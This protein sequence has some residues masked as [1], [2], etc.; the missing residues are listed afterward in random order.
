MTTPKRPYY[1]PKDPSRNYPYYEDDPYSR[2][3]PPTPHAPRPNPAGNDWSQGYDWENESAPPTPAPAPRW[4]NRDYD[5]DSAPP[6]PQS[7]ASSSHEWPEFA[8][9]SSHAGPLRTSTTQAGRFD[10]YRHAGESRTSRHDGGDTSGHGVASSHSNTVGDGPRPGASTPDMSDTSTSGMSS[11]SSGS[12]SSR[13]AGLGGLGQEPIDSA[14]AG[15][16][17]SSGGTAYF[18]GLGDKHVPTSPSHSRLAAL[19]SGSPPG[20]ST[21]SA[22][23]VGSGSQPPQ[24]PASPTA[25]PVSGATHRDP[26]GFA[27][28]GKPLSRGQQITPEIGQE[29]LELNR[30]GLSDPKIAEILKQKGLK[31][32]GKA[33][34]NY[35]RNVLKVGSAVAPKITPKVSKFIADNANK[36]VP[37]TEISTKLRGQ[38]VEITPTHISRYI[39]EKLNINVK[40]PVVESP[41]S[42][43]VGKRIAELYNRDY[44]DKDIS[45]ALAAE[46]T[47]IGPAAIGEHRR[48]KL[49]L[50]SRPPGGISGAHSRTTGNTGAGGSGLI[51]NDPAKVEQATR[52]MHGLNTVFRNIQRQTEALQREI[53]E[54]GSGATNTT[55]TRKLQTISTQTQHLADA[56]DTTL[57]TV[58]K[59]SEDSAAV[60]QQNAQRLRELR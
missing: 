1:D 18:A 3:M 25:T 39:R 50:W 51:V 17:G 16:H 31:T 23:S 53:S 37:A 10:P 15:S 9:E 19:L 55:A 2:P 35:R 4:L 26:E 14:S 57:E 28:P 48:K 5:L 27:V 47:K 21:A 46:G 38:G 40:T 7:Q 56:V 49:G 8:D 34:G 58:Q 13:P 12:S 29:I 33:V 41:I 45:V 6:T 22:R 11:A 60:E 20:P 59:A 30:K 24:P 54:S 43:E 44:P 52:Q 32:N 36:G 42:P